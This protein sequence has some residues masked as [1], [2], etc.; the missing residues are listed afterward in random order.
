MAAKNP[1]ILSE[2]PAVADCGIV[3]VVTIYIIAAT[4]NCFKTA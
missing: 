4:L 2:N 3:A 1:D